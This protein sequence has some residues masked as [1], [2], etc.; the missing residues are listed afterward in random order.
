MS[1]DA[2][3]VVNRFV[4]VVLAM[5]VAFA[6]VLVVVLAWGAPDGTIGRI[7]DF[8]D[9]LRDHDG[10]DAKV[11]ISL[12]ALI[13]LLLMLAAL[14][15][16]LTPSP[17]RV[18]RLR[19][20]RAGDATITTKEIAE[21]VKA[22]ALEV[23]HVRECQAVVAA[24]GR[25]VEA[26]LDLHVDPGAN[27]ADTAD[28]ACRRAQALIERTIGVE[29]AQ[30]PRARVHYRELHLRPEGPVPDTMRREALPEAHRGPPAA[31]EGIS[32]DGR[33][34]RRDD[35]RDAGAE[36]GDSGRDWRRP[37]EPGPGGP[38]EETQAPAD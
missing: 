15:L 30:P 36:R 2:A 26:V 35:G 7:S 5:L 12:G 29:L 14:V 20:V 31:A 22:E 38:P 6:A 16:E 25:R 23:P 4:V 17:T 28:E 9:W 3:D 10:R 24:R 27:L 37:G 11:I 21:R 13:I 18:M 1:D 19:S 8:A 33:D 32:D 34:D